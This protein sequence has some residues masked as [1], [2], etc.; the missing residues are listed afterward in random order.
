MHKSVSYDSHSRSNYSSNRRNAPLKHTR[1]LVNNGEN[2]GGTGL[3]RVFTRHKE[4]NNSNSV[5]SNTGRLSDANNRSKPTL[6]QLRS[7]STPAQLSNITQQRKASTGSF[8]EKPNTKNHFES[9][10][11]VVINQKVDRQKEVLPSQQQQPK[12]VSLKNK[13]K[14]YFYLIKASKFCFFCL[15]FLHN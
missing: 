7:D 2:N 13:K 5:K 15:L 14:V 3:I 6:R 11:A 9:L 8:L 1:N 4:G 12:S 10:D